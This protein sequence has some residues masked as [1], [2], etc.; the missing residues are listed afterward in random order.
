M[1]TSFSSLLF[2][3]LGVLFCG[4]TCAAGGLIEERLTILYL[5]GLEAVFYAFF[6]LDQVGEGHASD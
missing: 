5:I 2:R 3:L 1:W 6:G 4:A